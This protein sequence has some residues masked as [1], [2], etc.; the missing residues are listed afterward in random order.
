MKRAAAVYCVMLCLL[1]S[2]VLAEQRPPIALRVINLGSQPI[3]AFSIVGLPFRDVGLEARPGDV[4][5]PAFGD[6]AMDYEL[7]WRFRDGSVHAATLDLRAQLPASFHGNAFISLHDDRAA[8]T[9][10]NMDPAWI[11]YR[12]SNPP[13]KAGAPQVPLYENCSGPLLSDAIALKAWRESAERVRRQIEANPGWSETQRAEC[14]L[15][16]YVPHTP[17]RVRVEPEESEAD[18]LRREW[19]AEIEKLRR[20]R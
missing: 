6:G 13:W 16:R 12:R 18:R 15:E 3:I 8:I 4:L 5:T 19:R 2:P 1:G 14:D 10:S 17:G 7:Y 20:A 11:E 9:W